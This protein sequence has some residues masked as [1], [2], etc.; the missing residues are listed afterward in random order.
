[1][2]NIELDLQRVEFSI[3]EHKIF[4]QV[5]VVKNGE[6]IL[7]KTGFHIEIQSSDEIHFVNDH[8]HYVNGPQSKHIV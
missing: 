5:F 8:E 6:Q 7:Y 4:D 3:L 1:M 2:I